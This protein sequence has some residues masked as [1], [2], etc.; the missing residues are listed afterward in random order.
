MIKKPLIKNIDFGKPIE[1]E[2]L[3]NYEEGTVVSR[4][5]AQGKPLSVTL[6]AFD[7]GEEIS[8]HS[9]S[10]DAMAYILDGEAEIT[11]G[12]EKFNVKK[13]ETIVMPA[14]IPHALLATQKFKMLLTVVFSL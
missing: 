5:L 12:E 10:G 9:A 3:V 11:I 8:S 2:S 7:K 6:F 1:M 14:N 13:G 4:T